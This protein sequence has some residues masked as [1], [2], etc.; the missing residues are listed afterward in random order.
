ML[1]AA[2][3]GVVRAMGYGEAIGRGGG[4]EAMSWSNIDC[5]SERSSNS[6]LSVVI[7]E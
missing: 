3:S 4:G 6:C 5:Y 1:P 2:I 7:R